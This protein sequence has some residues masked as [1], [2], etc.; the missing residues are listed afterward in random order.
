MAD[1][2]LEVD[3]AAEWFAEQEGRDEGPGNPARPVGRHRIHLLLGDSIA[4]RAAFES[5]SPGD[6][7]LNRANSGETWTSLLRSV[8]THRVAW[9]MAA[10]AE[11]AVTGCCVIWLSGNDVY[12]RYSHRAHFNWTTLSAIGTTAQAVSRRLRPGSDEIVVLGPLARL[13]G[14]I[15]CAK[16]ETTAA[17]HLERTLSRLDDCKFVPLGRA[18]TR[19]MGKKKNGLKGCEQWYKP[20]GVH[21]S[22]EGYSKVVGVGAF[23]TW[24][25]LSAERR[26]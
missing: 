6:R 15:L 23:P 14:E 22:D 11:G 26:D 18:L 16:W 10:A 20:D 1:L 3:E 25:A 5:R 13:S 19:K 24:I 2:N 21:L 4:C 17:Y 12:S 9:Q 8:D 7:I